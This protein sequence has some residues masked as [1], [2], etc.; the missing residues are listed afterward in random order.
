MLV[1]RLLGCFTAVFASLSFGLATAPVASAAHSQEAMFM[2]TGGL[3]NDPAGTLAQLTKLGVDRVRLFIGWNRLA[4]RPLSHTRPR[5]FKAADPRSYPAARWAPLDRAIAMIK[6]AGIGVY[7][8]IGGG[9]PIWATA[10]GAPAGKP[11]PS[12]EPIPGEYGA[13]VRA[14]A[15]RYSG[16]YD[17]KTGTLDP[18]NTDDLPK[19]TFW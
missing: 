2:D 5:N 1:A 10:P 11:H 17:P 16:N 9:A 3:Y 7:V 19:V 15:T 14:V 13:F 6:A 8:D 4:P 12:W 18:G